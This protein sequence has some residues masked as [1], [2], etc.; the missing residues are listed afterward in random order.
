MELQ[1]ATNPARITI[2]WPCLP[3]RQQTIEFQLIQS[4][5]ESGQNPSLYTLHSVMAIAH[6]TLYTLYC[7]LYTVNFTLYN[8]HCTLY[9]VHCTIHCALQ[10]TLIK[11]QNRS[12]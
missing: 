10:N 9:S 3:Q 2:I 12:R 6:F 4:P 8:V 11:R 1:P 7:L 5:D